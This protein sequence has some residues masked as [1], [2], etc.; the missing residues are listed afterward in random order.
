MK[1]KE[2]ENKVALVTGAGRGIGRAISLALAGEGAQLILAGRDIPAL[3]GTAE[4]IASL[5][6]APTPL[7]CTIDLLDLA[8]I[9]N[10]V[11]QS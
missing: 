9:E 6:V 4:L 2:L 5:K 3:N 11:T 7:V 1:V 10:S 8:T